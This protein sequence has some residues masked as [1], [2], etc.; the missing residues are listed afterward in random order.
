MLWADDGEDALGRIDRMPLRDLDAL[1][2]GEF[3][4]FILRRGDGEGGLADRLSALDALPSEDDEIAS[5]RIRRRDHQPVK[6]VD[7][8]DP[9]AASDEMPIE[10]LADEIA[11]RPLETRGAH[12]GHIDAEGDL[13]AG[14]DAGGLRRRALLLLLL[15]R[16]GLRRLFLRLAFFCIVLSV[17]CARG[18]A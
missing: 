15:L 18:R 4:L 6:T 16:L 2:H 10:D 3:G 11:R 12:G 8:I 5:P 13:R 1:L 14:R 7:W 9:R 17:R